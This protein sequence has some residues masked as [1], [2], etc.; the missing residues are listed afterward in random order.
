MPTSKS[1]RSSL[2]QEFTRR[3]HRRKWPERWRRMAKFVFGPEPTAKQVELMKR[4][5]IYY[6]KCAKCDECYRLANRAAIKHL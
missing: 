1:K 6:T 3:E 4:V 2:A 5:W